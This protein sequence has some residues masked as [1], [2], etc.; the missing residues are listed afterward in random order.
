MKRKTKIICTIGPSTSS[1][2]QLFELLK[3]GATIFRLNGSH[4]SLEWHRE[5]IRRMRGVSPLTPILLDIPGKKV[6]V[7]A[8]KEDVRLNKGEQI[9][10]TTD[11]GNNN[12]GK[13]PVTYSRFHEDLKMGDTILADDGTLRFEV[14]AVDGRDI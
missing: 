12:L 6:R 11:P 8:F 5:V 1:E 13:V 4:N 10:F 14:V 3:M 2:G 7:G 9:V